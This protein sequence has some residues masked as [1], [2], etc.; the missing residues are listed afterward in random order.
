MDGTPKVDGVMKNGGFEGVLTIFHPNG[1]IW[2]KGVYKN[3]LKEGKWPNYFENG[4]LEREDIYKAGVWLNPVT[5]D[6]G[7]IEEK[8]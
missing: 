7:A 8:K 1:K 3:G 6:K 5:D 2:Q 4:E